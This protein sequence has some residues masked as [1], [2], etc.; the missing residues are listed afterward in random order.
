[1]LSHVVEVWIVHVADLPNPEPSKPPGADQIIGLVA[2]VKWAAGIALLVGFFMGLVVWAGGRWVD[3][4]RAGKV[5][6]V[7]M[8]CAVG[9]ALLYGIGWT[10]I[11][12][13]AGTAK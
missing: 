6:L 2:N 13:F 9:G 10:V 8:L 11:N 1:M 5:G 3:H 4:H 12:G 7:M